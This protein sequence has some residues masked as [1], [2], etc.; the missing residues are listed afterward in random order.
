MMVPVVATWVVHHAIRSLRRGEPHFRHDNRQYRG[1]YYERRCTQ[2]IGSA[3]GIFELLFE[4]SVCRPHQPCARSQHVMLTIALGMLFDLIVST[5]TTDL[6]DYTPPSVERPLLLFTPASHA[7]H[8]AHNQ[9]CAIQ[10]H[11]H[12]EHAHQRRRGPLPDVLVHNL[13][14][15]RLVEMRGAT[16]HLGAQVIVR[17]LNFLVLI[18]AERSSGLQFLSGK[19]PPPGRLPRRAATARCCEV[20]RENVTR[21]DVFLTGLFNFSHC[22][23]SSSTLVYTRP[24]QAS[25]AWS[26]FFWYAFRSCPHAA[27]ASKP[28]LCRMLAG[29]FIP[30][31]V[32]LKFKMLAR[33][34]LLKS[35]ASS[36]GL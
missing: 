5:S 25:S 2:L 9:R 15:R 29:T 23:N 4:V 35:G 16:R 12:H 24:S 18:H 33:P 19:I 14:E 32:F 8:R 22:N 7:N 26:A 28:L 3:R 30:S 36:T 34:G 11:E 20:D 6:A 10:E 13:F 17:R 31:R 21:L 27:A 1:R